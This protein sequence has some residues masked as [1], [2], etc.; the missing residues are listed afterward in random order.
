MT[1]EKARRTKQLALGAL[2]GAAWFAL[3]SQTQ[4]V[5][6]ADPSAWRAMAVTFC[7]IALSSTAAW[8]A[9]RGGRIGGIAA[10]TVATLWAAGL[11]LWLITLS[12]DLTIGFRG[13]AFILHSPRAIFEVGGQSP[14]VASAAVMTLVLARFGTVRSNDLDLREHRAD[15]QDV[16]PE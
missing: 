11:A 12:N 4:C 15:A 9:L 16:T 3:A 10:L 6:Y 8:L 5:L 7:V 1:K 2:A 14:F 13:G